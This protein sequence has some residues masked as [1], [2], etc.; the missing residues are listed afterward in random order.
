MIEVTTD[1]EYIR[2]IVTH[3]AVWAYAVD[4]GSD[5]ATWQPPMQ[6]VVWLTMP[7]VVGVALVY[8]V[9]GVIYA[10]DAAVLPESRAP[11]VNYTKRR[12]YIEELKAWLRKNTDCKHL[13]GIIAEDNKR[14][15]R[16]AEADGLTLEGRLAKSK[17]RGEV[18]IDALIYGT[19]V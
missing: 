18:F 14:S 13:I 3:P 8:R 15:I 19:G 7:G 11:A 6:G 1:T 5:P 16:A 2:A 12:D 9:S 4:Q 17:K 10:Y